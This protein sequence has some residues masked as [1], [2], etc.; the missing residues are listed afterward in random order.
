L[1]GEVETG[2]ERKWICDNFSRAEIT[3]WFGISIVVDY[4]S[5]VNNF[6]PRI[7]ENVIISLSG[8]LWDTTSP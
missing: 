2:R 5:Q 7:Q 6:I 1:D 3:G 4:F 8:H